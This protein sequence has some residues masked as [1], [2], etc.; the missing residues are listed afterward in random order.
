MFA[1]RKNRYCE[2]RFCV[3]ERLP[4][5]LIC[6]HHVPS[7]RPSLL[8][9]AHKHQ[10]LAGPT[11]K[12][13]ETHVARED[14]SRIATRTAN[15]RSHLLKISRAVKAAKPVKRE[16]EL[17]V[18]TAA[19]AWEASGKNSLRSCSS[20][21]VVT[22]VHQPGSQATLKKL[23][24]PT[25]LC[26]SSRDLTIWLL[27]PIAIRQSSLSVPWRTITRST[28]YFV[29]A[30]VVANLHSLVWGVLRTVEL[31]CVIPSIT[32]SR[33]CSINSP[34]TYVKAPIMYKM[35]VRKEF[36]KDALFN[37]NVSRRVGSRPLR[38]KTTSCRNRSFSRVQNPA[39]SL[40]K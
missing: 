30:F 10:R 2:N 31:R 12:A 33:P 7:P 26:R 5:I 29:P 19:N 35:Y 22:R 23:S 38:I 24:S 17:D 25:L 8:R 9:L 15:V 16:A 39:C 36:C 28:E 3:H 20:P 40:G 18:N 27:N 6:I 21:S 13:N 4:H 32:Q 34:G 11:H 14:S 1:R 37:L